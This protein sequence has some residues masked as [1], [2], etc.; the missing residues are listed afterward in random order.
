ME[1][2]KCGK[3]YPDEK[4]ACPDC[5]YVMSKAERK[6]YIKD[7]R[8]RVKER[9]RLDRDKRKQ[10]KT[11]KEIESER[12]YR[13]LCKGYAKERKAEKAEG[14][15]PVSAVLISTE[16]KKSGTFGRALVG[17]ALFGIAGSIAGAAS[18]TS[19]ATKATFSVKY[20]SGRTGT[21]TVDI[22]SRRFKELS[23]LLHK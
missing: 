2:I 12:R 7:L 17:G 6:E 1:C 9:E 21:E 4:K 20:A 5:G 14:K 18:G 11:P 19:K 13:E 15:R 3:Y 16:M 8:L 23:A 10:P 22:G